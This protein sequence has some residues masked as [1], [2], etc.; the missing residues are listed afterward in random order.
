MSDL[1]KKH[2]VPC[3]GGTKPLQKS[4]IE[5][6][7][8]NVK[9]WNVVDD[10]KIEKKFHFIDFKHAISFV[11]EVADVAEFEGHHPDIYLHNWNKVTLTFSTHAIKGL[12]END[13][14]MAAKVDKLVAES[15]S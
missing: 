5:I 4:E 3:E 15:Y 11:Q 1:I 2:C 13:F 14:I 10:I 9:S 12:S 7:A 6:L 8:K